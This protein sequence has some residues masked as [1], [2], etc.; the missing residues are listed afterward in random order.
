[1]T[2]VRPTRIRRRADFLRAAREGLKTGRPNMVVQALARPDEATRL[3]FTATRK[4]G[5]AVVRNRAKRRL[6]AVARLDLDE[7][8]APGWDIVL[9]AR[10]DTAT[11]PFAALWADFARALRQV[12]VRGG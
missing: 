6:R 12:G 9:I 10:Q 7:A 5:G 3:G 8:P 2:A 1:M 4:I 11:A